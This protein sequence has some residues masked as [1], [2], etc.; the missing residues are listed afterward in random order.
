ML[1]NVTPD[2][3]T[4]YHLLAYAD[5][6]DIV[7]NAT[8]NFK[9]SFVKIGKAANEPLDHDEAIL[10]KVKSCRR[11]HSKQEICMYGSIRDNMTNQF[12]IKT[13]MEL[14]KLYNQTDFVK[15]ERLRWTRCIES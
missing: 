3:P 6:I 9:E 15:S 4:P 2:K 7:G 11:K 13:N 10:K 8:I 5:Y 12:R 14:E 1:F